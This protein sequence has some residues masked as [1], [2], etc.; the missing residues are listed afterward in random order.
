MA[1]AIAHAEDSPDALRAF[2]TRG[3]ALIDLGRLPEAE[4][5]LMQTIDR[6]RI[7]LGAQHPRT[8]ETL[9]ALAQLRSAQGRVAE[10]AD[11]ADQALAAAR[12]QFAVG[13][14]VLVTALETAAHY[15]RAAGR[16]GAAD[17]LT[18]EARH[19]RS[20]VA[21]ASPPPG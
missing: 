4:A 9:T 5:V 8:L 6:D 15:Q 13:S 11:L 1:Q 18:Q 10:A 2:A 16:S 20:A 14:P 3:I 17:R 12:V 7:V 19:S 21:G